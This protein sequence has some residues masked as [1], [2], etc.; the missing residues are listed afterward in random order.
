MR[1]CYIKQHIAVQRDFL[2]THLKLHLVSLT[3]TALIYTE[4]HNLFLLYV[5]ILSPGTSNWHNCLQLIFVLFTES[6]FVNLETV[7]LFIS[8]LF[9]AI[10]R[11]QI[12]PKQLQTEN[13]ESFLA[14]RF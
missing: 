10:I 4:I 8:V 12:Q 3:Y 5:L 11:Q 9:V 2:T 14:V 6:K 7:R 1:Y 13:T